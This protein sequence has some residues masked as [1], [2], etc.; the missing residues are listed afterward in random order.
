MVG[1]GAG[2]YLLALFDRGKP[3]APTCGAFAAEPGG[4]GDAGSDGGGASSGDGGAGPGPDGG[5]VAGDGGA[6]TGDG[7]WANPAASNGSSGGCGCVAG[8]ARS[9]GSAL[10]GFAPLALLAFRR[11]RR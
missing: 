1:F 6:G 2:A 4:A 10:V 9:T 3:A 7:G 8:D 11:R 5:I